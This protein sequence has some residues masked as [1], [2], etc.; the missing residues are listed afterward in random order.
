MSN[1][2]NPFGI[3]TMLEHALDNAK[4]KAHDVKGMAKQYAQEKDLHISY[5][6]LEIQFIGA[7]GLPKTDLTGLSDPYFVATLDDKIKFI[8]TVQPYTLKPV[9]NELWK[10]K[11]VPVHASL[12]VQVLD[13][14][15]GTPVDDYIGK[16]S[17]SVSP[18]PKEA[19]IEGP[20]LKRNRGTFWLKIES[21]PSTNDPQSHP[22]VFDGPIRYS[23]HFSPLVGRLTNI[24]DE[25]LY[26]TWKM[27]IKDLKGVSLFFGDRVQHWNVNYKAAQAIFQGPASPAVRSGIQ[28]GHRMLYARSTRNGFGVINGPEDIR[29]IL[30]G[31]NRRGQ[32]DNRFEHRVKPAVYTYVIAVED[33][34]FRFSETGAAFFVDFASKHALHSNCAEAVR[35]SG[36]FHP[37]PKGGWE[38]FSDDTP[39][40]ETEWE[41]VIDN[42]SGTYAPD[43]AL[44]PDLK[45]LLEYNF[46]GFKIFALDQ[47]DPELDQS[48]EACRA[49]ALRHRGVKNTELQPHTEVGE[50]VLSH[51]VETQGNHA[52]GEP[53]AAGGPLT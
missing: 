46:P 20:L 44:L 3:A 1:V 32:N 13:K 16:F 39:D 24:N 4:D 49:Y 31:G 12:N 34:S 8:S 28:A 26:C 36:E 10:V 40:T 7:S 43:K 14:D 52:P 45:A 9:W 27:Y 50:P 33:D 38:N 2:G 19:E 22:Y 17:T 42:N 5:V 29:A 30:H 23:R 53:Y 6:D 48:R 41:L 15:D 11:N 35:Y 21:T 37:R 47:K 25:R 51:E 18:G